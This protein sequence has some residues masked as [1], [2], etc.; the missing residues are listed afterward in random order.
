MTEADE[1]MSRNPWLGMVVW[2]GILL[3][4]GLVRAME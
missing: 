2:V 1:I 4:D 3:L